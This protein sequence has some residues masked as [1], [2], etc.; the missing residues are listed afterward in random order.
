MTM[1]KRRMFAAE[2]ALL[3]KMGKDPD[4]LVSVSAPASMAGNPEET[5]QIM[6]AI[7]D[8]KATIVKNTDPKLRDDLPELGVLR[9]QLQEMANSIDAT[10][11]EIAAVR[12]PDATD[13]RL[14]SAAM[15]LDAIVKSTEDATHNILSATEDIEDKLQE[16]KDR[17][18]DV[19]IQKM[20]D[21][22]GMMTGKIYE[23]CNFQDI[24]GQRT[25]KVVK[26]IYFL[27]DRVMTMIDIW[28]GTDEF[29]AIAHAEDERDEDEKLLDGPQHEGAGVS[30]NDID[31]LF[32]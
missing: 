12:H 6:A 11:K 5:K 19:G 32:D 16:I 15:E 8:L 31:A 27:E 23:N 3:E 25:T 10:K 18:A 1:Q 30:Q 29:K 22:I 2:R 17:A 28:G 7:A 21:E 24:T 20:I 13:D 4:S 9:A 26:T 14:T